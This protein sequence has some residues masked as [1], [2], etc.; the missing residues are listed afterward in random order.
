MLKYKTEKESFSDKNHCSKNALLILH[1]KGDG[2]LDISYEN[3]VDRLHIWQRSSLQWFPHFHDSIEI[4]CMLS[5]S[6]DMMIGGENYTIGVG[7]VAISMPNV[8]HGYYRE[9]DVSAYLLIV[10]RHYCSAFSRLLETH[11]V[12]EPIIRADT[13]GGKLTSRI[14][15]LIRIRRSRSP[16]CQEIMSGCFTMLFGEIFSYTGMTESRQ[17][18]EETERRLIAYCMEHYEQDISLTV[19]AD[20]LHV[21]RSYISYM[22]SNKLHVSLPDFIGSLRIAEAKR[23]IKRGVGVTEAAMNAGFSSIR[24]F[25][26]R[27]YKENGMTPRE[28]KRMLAEA[29]GDGEP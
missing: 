28:Y 12:R 18:P 10:P 2:T 29:G 3:R 20:A 6:V 1:K 4:A 16:F 13:H 8:L 22:F 14:E 25:N 19:L 23:Q 11:T 27:F 7:D 15:E 9:N 26:R 24:T 17:V 21:S 5:G